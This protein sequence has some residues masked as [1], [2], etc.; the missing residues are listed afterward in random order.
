MV[1]S[2]GEKNAEA[3]GLNAERVAEIFKVINTD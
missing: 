3:N 1:R 2:W